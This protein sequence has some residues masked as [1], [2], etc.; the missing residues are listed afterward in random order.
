VY[1]S[2]F[3]DDALQDVRRLPK[4]VKNRLKQEFKRKIHRDPAGCSEPLTGL[5]KEFRS[6][7]LGDYRVVYRI[8]EDM[9]VVAVVG[10]GKK[11]QGHRAELYEQL[12]QLA[13][14]GKLAA[15]V[16]D[17]YRSLETRRPEKA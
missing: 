9:E 8:F 6:F 17:V 11:D 3:T 1:R 2:E 14:T 5:L 16:L 15:A 4:N 10:I 12:E 7:H 13:K